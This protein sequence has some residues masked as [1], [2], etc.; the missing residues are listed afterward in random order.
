MAKR[1]WSFLRVAFYMMRKGLLSKRKLLMDMNL[2]MKRGKVLGKK[3]L[4]NLIHHH[5]RSTG[6]SI[7]G[8]Y[9]LREYEFSCSN[10]PVP[11]FFHAG[12]KRKHHH[13]YFPC[14]NLQEEPETP[15]PSSHGLPAIQL[16]PEYSFNFRND[17][18]PEFADL[19][20]RLISP[21]VSP[22]SVRVSNFSG[23]EENDGGSRQ[24]DVEAEEFITKFYEQLKA[25]RSIA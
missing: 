22:F 8:G 18:S 10:S 15:P 4:G 2:M 17:Q 23:V 25:Q 19:G 9:G 11:V 13:H 14:I 7:S 3:T 6:R 1:L 16:S 5:H 24:V 20:E 12:C 21:M